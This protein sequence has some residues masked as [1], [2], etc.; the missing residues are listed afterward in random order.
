MKKLIIANWK[1]NPATTGK[2]LS[3]FKA[4]IALPRPKNTELIICPP[5]IY[6]EEFAN[7]KNVILGAQ[8]DFWEAGG[9]YTGEISPKMLRDLKVKYVIIGHSERRR[10]A[11]ET[12]L[13]I[14]KK[15]KA[16]VKE[17]LSAILCVGET[18]EIRKRGKSAAK[19]F[20]LGQLKKDLAGVSAKNL[21]DG[22][23]IIA[24]EPVWAIG[25]GKS[26]TTKNAREMIE[27]V[28]MS[29][30]G[31][32]KVAPKVIYGGSVN[33]KNAGGFIREPLIDGALVGGASLKIG[34]FKKI[35]SAA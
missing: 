7:K 30:E 11:G 1:M 2:A 4:I 31:K 25:T 10:W 23:V 9:P 24:Y 15:I 32:I 29:F 5:F 14:N 22:K 13:M 19:K 18:L 16:T 27:Y 26:D 34:E 17:G 28:K 12:D 33:S 3:L 8:D 35:L 21:S 20:V 6:L